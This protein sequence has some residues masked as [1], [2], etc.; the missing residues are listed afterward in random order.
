MFTNNFALYKLTDRND[1][2]VSGPPL[3]LK[4]L[5][6]VPILAINRLETYLTCRKPQWQLRFEKESPFSC[7]KG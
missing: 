6:D 2:F 3:N 7:P 1:N 4:L 5:S